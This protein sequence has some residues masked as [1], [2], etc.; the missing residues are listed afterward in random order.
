M[1]VN[2]FGKPGDGKSYSTVLFVGLF[3]IAQKRRWLNNINGINPVEINAYMNGLVARS[4]AGYKEDKPVFSFKKLALNLIAGSRSTSGMDS[5]EKRLLEVMRKH[6]T[7]TGSFDFSPFVLCVDEEDVKKPDFWFSPEWASSSIMQPGDCVTID[8]A[9]RYFGTGVKIAE[10]TIMCILKHRHYVAADSGLS[11]D[12]YFIA[13]QPG[14]LQRE[15]AGNAQFTYVARRMLAVGALK[16]NRFRLDYY[17]GAV[18]ATDIKKRDFYDHQE[19]TLNPRVFK[20]YKSFEGEKGFESKSNVVTIWNL[21]YFGLPLFK[22]WV[23]ACLVAIIFGIFYVG[24]FFYGGALMSSKP[25]AKPAV[26]AAASDKPAVVRP[27]SNTPT[28]AVPAV[29]ANTDI[30]RLTG[31]YTIGARTIAVISDSN[32]RIRYISDFKF[33]ST[34]PVTEIE[35]HGQ[36]IGYWSGSATQLPQFDKKNNAQTSS[37]LGR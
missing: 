13:Q 31:F 16:E 33:L 3:A 21:K 23:P 2:I 12:L 8:E 6:G 35:W 15:V 22:F 5:T 19:E 30:Y 7:D 14:H 29:P 27:V 9:R 36:I 37:F 34:G 17:E 20:L 18:G 32:S 28:T 25:I 24:R 4:V 26:S 1:Q 11:I 10:R